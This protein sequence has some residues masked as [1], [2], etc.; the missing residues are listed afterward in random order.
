MLLNRLRSATT[1]HTYP[2]FSLALGKGAKGAS[3]DGFFQAPTAVCGNGETALEEGYRPP[4]PL[5]TFST[6]L[7]RPGTGTTVLTQWHARPCS[8][9]T[10]QLERG[11]I[12][13]SPSRSA[14]R[15]QHTTACTMRIMQTLKCANPTTIVHTTIKVRLHHASLPLASCITAQ[16]PALRYP[17]EQ[18]MV[19][20]KPKGSSA[21]PHDDPRR[22]RSAVRPPAQRPKNCRSPR[23]W[24]RFMSC[25]GGCSAC[26]SN[27]DGT[28]ANVG[29]RALRDEQSAKLPG[30]HQ[31][32]AQGMR[33]QQQE[34][35]SGQRGRGLPFP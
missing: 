15:R 1:L 7:L 18:Q 16:L 33:A 29:A 11:G 24:T 31:L 32:Q 6:R 5:I 35:G 23:S 34:Q 8:T 22:K 9:P 14:H 10:T 13:P 30:K 27:V 26:S 19:A 4:P 20:D 25:R 12:P 3:W 21:T 2:P 28:P 17:T